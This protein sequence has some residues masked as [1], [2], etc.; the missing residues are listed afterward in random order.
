LRIGTEATGKLVA[1]EEA[2]ALI[3]A[4]GGS[5][6]IP[7]LTCQDEAR[8]VWVGDVD[9]SEV[10]VGSNVLIAGAG[11]TGCEAALRFIQSGRKVTLIDTLPREQLGSGSSPINAYALFNILAESNVDIRTQ[12]KLVDVTQD[13]AIVVKGGRED[14]LI[15]DTVILSLGTKVDTEAIKQLR[16]AVAECYVVGNSNGKSGTVWNATTSAFDAAMAV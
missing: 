5:P 4:T 7:K 9:K 15:F 6:V 14:R 3:L 11:L 10:L 16:T 1:E 2:E 13:Y 12:T 8:V